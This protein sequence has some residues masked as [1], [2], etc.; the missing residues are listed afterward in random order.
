M[1]RLVLAS[2]NVRLSHIAFAALF[3]VVAARAVRDRAVRASLPFAAPALP[4]LVAVFL[5]VPGTLNPVKTAGYAAWAVFD[6]VAV[7]WCVQLF[8]R[9]H[10][11]LRRWAIGVH[12][13]AG[14]TVVAAGAAELIA[15][16]TDVGWP[17]PQSFVTAQDRKSVV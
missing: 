2:Y 10:P 7:L 15:N 11:A 8:H 16:V 9:Q 5:S 6:V 3:L 12:V 14:L 4:Y 17:F 1:L 13:V